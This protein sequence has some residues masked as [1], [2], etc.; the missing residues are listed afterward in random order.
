MGCRAKG[1][2]D[3]G[4]EGGPSSGRCKET[5]ASRMLW[6]AVGTLPEL[7][8]GPRGRWGE[9]DRGPSHWAG[10]E[11]RGRGGGEARVVR[12][13]VGEDPSGL[14]LSDG[15]RTWTWKDGRSLRPW[16]GMG[17]LG[18]G[19]RGQAGGHPG[20]YSRASNA[21]GGRMEGGPHRCLRQDL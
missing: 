19:H 17:S 8:E 18:G 15:R 2:V 9:L 13:R 16:W 1:G 12:K 6:P 20:W 10:P 5:P 14:D 7:G 3:G 21:L 4:Q 11:W